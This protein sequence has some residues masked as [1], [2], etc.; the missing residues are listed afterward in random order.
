MSPSSHARSA[1]RYSARARPSSSPSSPSVARRLLDDGHGGGRRRT[2]PGGAR[3][4]CARARSPLAPDAGQSERGARRHGE[5]GELLRTGG[6]ARLDERRDQL[7]Q[8][9]GALL[10]RR[11]RAARRRARG[12][13]SRPAG[14]RARAPPCAAAASRRPARRELGRR[15]AG[16]LVLVAAG[17][18]EMERRSARRPPAARRR[19]LSQ[20]AWRSCSRARAAFASE[21]YAT[22][23]TRPW[24]KRSARPRRAPRAGRA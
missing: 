16:D 15:G 24:R 19:A 9:L 4:G 20:A 8:Q 6:R 10:A 18:L 3:A 21:A 17:G 13:R 22:S 12:S 23:R 1:I 2:S 5:L 14:R 7:G 11:C